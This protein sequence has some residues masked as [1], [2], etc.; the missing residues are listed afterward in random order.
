MKIEHV[1]AVGT[2]VVVIKDR[3]AEKRASRTID[4]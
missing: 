3:V 1:A 4:E 2:V